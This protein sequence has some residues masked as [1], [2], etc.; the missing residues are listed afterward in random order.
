[1]VVVNRLAPQCTFDTS[2]VSAVHTDDGATLHHTQV[3]RTRWSEYPE[4]LYLEGTW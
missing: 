3:L 4:H 2:Q 1:M